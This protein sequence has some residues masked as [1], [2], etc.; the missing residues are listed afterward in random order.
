MTWLHKRTTI[1]AFAALA[2]CV[3]TIA[4]FIYTLATDGDALSLALTGGAALLALRAAYYQL[5]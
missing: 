4:L 1:N 3:A 5:R 2:L